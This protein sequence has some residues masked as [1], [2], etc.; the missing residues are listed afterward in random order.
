MAE[1]E[2][3]WVEETCG[4]GAVS[5]VDYSA[6]SKREILLQALPLRVE[7]ADVVPDPVLWMAG[8]GWYAHFICPWM[9]Q[10]EDIRIDRYHDESLESADG[11]ILTASD[12]SFLIGREISAVTSDENM[13]DA[14]FHLSGGIELVMHTDTDLDPWV[15]HIPGITLVG[16]TC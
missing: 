8:D 5:D 11:S 1:P 12:L 9:V 10:G 15:I 3:C 7:N 16:G 14:T 6:M 4:V 13:I 2:R